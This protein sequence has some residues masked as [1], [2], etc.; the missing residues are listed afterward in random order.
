MAITNFE[1]NPNEKSI[2]QVLTEVY[3]VDEAN[4]TMAAI[5]NSIESEYSEILKFRQDLSYIPAK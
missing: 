4:S 5:D 2:P 3:G 1:P